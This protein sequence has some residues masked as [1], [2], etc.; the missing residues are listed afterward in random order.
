VVAAIEQALS[1]CRSRRGDLPWNLTENYGHVQEFV[2]LPFSRLHNLW[3][4]MMALSTGYF[5]FIVPFQLALSYNIGEE[6]LLNLGF[7]I[8]FS[9]TFVVDIFVRS[10]I[11]FV[12]N[13]RGLTDI[14]TDVDEIQS[15][16]VNNMLIFDILAAVPIDYILLP[17]G[18]YGFTEELLRYVRILKL[19]KFSRAYETIKLYQQ[20]S[21]W[22][23]AFLTFSL[24]AM[25]YILLSHY[26]AACYIFVGQREYGKKTRFDG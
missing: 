17:F 14:V 4:A 11:A 22:S 26:M 7:D 24:Y 5:L 6:S 13:D 10:R 23:S 15:Y 12:V 2:I 21:N 19:T 16:Y 3:T 25:A 9:F 20:Q 18:T 8:F 1:C